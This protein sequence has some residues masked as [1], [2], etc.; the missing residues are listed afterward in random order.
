MSR[1]VTPESTCGS[2]WGQVLSDW[3][4]ADKHRHRRRHDNS[5]GDQSQFIYQKQSDSALEASATFYHGVQFRYPQNDASITARSLAADPTTSIATNEFRCSRSDRSPV[6][7]PSTVNNDQLLPSITLHSRDN[8]RDIN[9]SLSSES[10]G[11]EVTAGLSAQHQQ[12]ATSLSP[13]PRRRNTSRTDAG[14]VPTTSLVS[15]SNA[16]ALRSAVSRD[17]FED[18][19][20]HL[21]NNEHKTHRAIARKESL[22]AGRSPQ[23]L[24]DPP[25]SYSIRSSPVDTARHLALLPPIHSR[26]PAISCNGQKH[27]D[28]DQ[29]ESNPINVLHKV[30]SLLSETKSSDGKQQR[31]KDMT[32]HVIN[33]TPKLDKEDNPVLQSRS[34]RSRSRSRDKR[35]QKTIEAQ[36][37]STTDTDFVSFVRS[38][39]HR[40]AH[41]ET[42]IPPLL[43]DV[44]VDQHQ[45]SNYL[46]DAHSIDHL[47]LLR[48]AI[49]TDSPI[50][51]KV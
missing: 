2:N 32:Q 45:N 21:I 15:V 48:N 19:D 6:R 14:V 24:G 9:R 41:Q 5:S 40:R 28:S 51:Q 7:S 13:A 50:N 31:S 35:V 33:T 8:R 29:L 25:P 12:R 4:E 17:E 10:R 42:E 18:M 22:S 46:V 26:L 1:L 36:D 49:T 23:R 37:P 43:S 11:E 3:L 16:L 38:S 47:L 39:V 27:D 44:V 34:H 20:Y 30:D